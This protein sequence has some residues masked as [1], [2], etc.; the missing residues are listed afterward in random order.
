M[1]R[2]QAIGVCVV[3]LFCSVGVMGQAAGEKNSQEV[4]REA[5]R[6]RVLDI[7]MTRARDSQARAE[8]VRAQ[9]ES[10]QDRMRK[11]GGLLEVTPEGLRQMV[12]RLQRQAESLEVEEAGAKGRQAALEAAIAKYSVQMK[13]R[14]DGDEVTQELS[15]V[16]ETRK[17]QLGRVKQ[18][19]KQAAVAQGEV[20]AA[21]AAVAQ[22]QAEVAASRQR[23]AGAAGET[24]EA[25]NRELVNLSI[26]AQER[27]AKLTFLRD[28]LK[29]L[30]PALADA[31]ELEQRVPEVKRAERWLDEALESLHAL[32]LGSTR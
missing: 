30:E 32:E 9:V 16:L 23:A 18:L 5:E 8:A 7:A 4:A 12:D 28:R 15:K 25:W 22:A 13:L 20:D 11:A 10:I 3:I 29:K 31:R 21:E 14:A 2:W 1:K 19:Q 24:L 6:Q 26:A 17:N 27:N